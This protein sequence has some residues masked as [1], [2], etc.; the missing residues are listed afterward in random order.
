MR[1]VSFGAMREGV[2]GS[3]LCRQKTDQPNIAS[4]MPAS[5]P[6]CR[7]V[8]SER[9]VLA[10]NCM[11]AG[12]HGEDS[13]VIAAQMYGVMCPHILQS[14]APRLFLDGIQGSNSHGELQTASP[15][16]K[17]RRLV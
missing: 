3:L 7:M 15:K 6:I 11:F 1:R 4:G 10:V 14:R 2:G 13:K 5:G 9:D 16:I 12:R 17:E 8:Q